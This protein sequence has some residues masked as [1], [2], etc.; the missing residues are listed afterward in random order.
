MAYSASTLPSLQEFVLLSQDSPYLE[1]YRRR[2]DWQRECYA[3]TQDVK[4][5]SVGLTLAVEEL[6]Q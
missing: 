1:L 5:E 3:G 6:Y 4:L 2:T